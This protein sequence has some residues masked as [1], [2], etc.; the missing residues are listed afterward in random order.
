MTAPADARPEYGPLDA[1]VAQVAATHA[2]CLSCMAPSYSHG[3]ANSGG[4]RPVGL[5][6]A[7]EVARRYVALDDLHALAQAP[8][9]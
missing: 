1:W 4:C 6:L 3:G 7:V 9:S 2:L 5:G 8:S